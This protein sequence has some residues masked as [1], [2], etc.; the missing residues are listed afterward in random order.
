MSDIEETILF[1]EKEL[2]RPEVR[3]SAEKIAN[4][5]SESFF[6]FGSSGNIYHY[7]KGDIFLEGPV[8]E[9][10]WEI[11]DFTLVQVSLDSVLATYTSIKHTEPVAAQK[12]SLRCSLWEKEDGAWKVKFHQGAYVGS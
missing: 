8:N 6:E 7:H 2:L 4:L 10:D 5:L 1:N 12:V 9:G 3:R 11:T